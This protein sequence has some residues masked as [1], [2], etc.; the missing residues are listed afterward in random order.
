MNVK[1]IRKINLMNIPQ[2]KNH[3]YSQ[4][5]YILLVKVI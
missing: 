2:N 1:K 5:C 4:P 3:F